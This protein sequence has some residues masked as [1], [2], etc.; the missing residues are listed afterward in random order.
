MGSAGRTQCC[1]FRNCFGG[2]SSI[3]SSDCKV[4][5]D[6]MTKR[7]LAKR[8]I[9]LLAAATLPVTV[10]SDAV[11]DAAQSGVPLPLAREV[12]ERAA[13][14]GVPTAEALAPVTEAAQRGLPPD[15]VAAKVLEGLSK[16]VPP[17]R[18]SAV[19]RDLAT[20]LATA[21]GVLGEAR[22]GGLAPAA[23]RKAALLDLGAALGAG[24]TRQA[25]DSL[26]GAA[27]ESR[28]GSTD[29]VV[30][31]AHTLGELA[32]RGVPPSEALG[33][34]LAIARRGPR[35]PAEIPALF[36]A[37]RAEGGEDASGFVAEAARRIENGRKLD[38][39]VDLFGNSPNHLVI[40]RG[41]DKD[42]DRSGLIDSDVGRRGADQGLTPGEEPGAAH[43]AVPGLDDAVHGRGKGPKKK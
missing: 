30:S 15:L 17:A 28:G 13:E 26:V 40:D 16:G 33:L 1:G 36:E 41:P 22:G 34:G 20:R 2:R 11:T 8:I 5:P 42:K 24:V 4:G 10:R 25:V 3:Q 23:D 9:A 7:I 31:A 6:V 19:A 43:G 35:P 29:A 27:R 14:R 32:R 21:D 38:G 18:I 39:M 37:W 12:A